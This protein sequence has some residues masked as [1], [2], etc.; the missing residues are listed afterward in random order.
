MFYSRKITQKHL[1]CMHKG[2]TFAPAL[3]EKPARQLE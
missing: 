3:G 1:V 2:T